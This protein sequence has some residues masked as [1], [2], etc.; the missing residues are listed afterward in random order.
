MSAGAERQ[1]LEREQAHIDRA[2][3]ALDRLRE[4][5][6]GAEPAPLDDDAGAGGTYQDRFQRERA[7][8]DARRRL[9]QLRWGDPPLVFGRLDLE[10]PVGELGR[11]F[12]VGR[13]GVFDEH[14]DQLVVDWRAPVAEGFYRATR[15]DPMGVRRRRAFRCRGRRLLGIDDVVLAGV[16]GDDEALLGEAALLAALEAPRTGRLTDVVATVQ[17]EQDEVIRAPMA[18]ITIVQGGAG[19]GKTVVALHRAAYLLYTYREVLDRQ[20]VLLLGPNGRFLD[21]VR[22]VLPALGEHDARLATVHDLFPGVEAVPDPDLAVATVKA[23]LRMARLLRRAV[24]TRQRHVRAGVAVPVGR[25]LLKLDADVVNAVVDEGRQLV[26]THNERRRVVESDLVDALYA[27]LVRRNTAKEDRMRDPGRDGLAARLSSTP[28]FRELL[29]RVWPVLR[30]QELLHDLFGSHA[31][32]RHAARGG[33]L[34]EDEF[35]LLHRPRSAR[36]TEVTWT[37][38]DVPLLHEAH[39]LLG[40]LPRATAVSAEPTEDEQFL[41]DR[42][43]EHV[44][45]SM[46]GIQQ[47][48]DP[49]MEADLRRSVLDE[50]RVDTGTAP[51]TERPPDVPEVWGTVLVDEAQDLSP[52]AWRMVARTCPNQAMTIVGDLAQGTAPW[53][54]ASWDEVVRCIEPRHPARRHELHVNY[55]TPTEVMAWADPFAAAPGRARAARRSGHEPEAFSVGAAELLGVVAET[56]ARLRDRRP[57]GTTAV[58][59]GPSWAAGLREVV[60]HD[61]E[62]HT[63]ESVKGLEFDGVVVVEPSDLVGGPAGT[64]PLYIALTR[65]T[66]HLAVIH[67]SPLPGPLRSVVAGSGLG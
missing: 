65:A 27:E 9:A 25:F 19:T 2:Y 43:M 51:P 42:V 32:L 44:E 59:A 13:V 67:A 24:R 20:G 31:L 62:V 50:I 41:V 16:T 30:P 49:V 57:E 54:P 66:T 46:T 56:A 15:A 21:H 10:E 37:H 26:G 23:D 7:T 12:H 6:A 33:L 61:V 34:R 55:R 45:A 52:M 3:A 36:W 4:G 39:A 53:S 35:A 28:A 48:L 29:E 17:A 63:P 58:V 11:R 47:G 22:D 5:A 38:A 64:A 14:H 18:G 1:E 60:P 40:P 8:A